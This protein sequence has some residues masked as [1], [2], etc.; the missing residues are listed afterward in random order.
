MSSLPQRE[1]VRLGVVTPGG[2]PSSAARAVALDGPAN[3]G[4]PVREQLEAFCAA[5]GTVTGM[6]VTARG[7]SHYREL[8]DAMLGGDVDLAWL[9]PVVAMRAAARGRMV[10]IALPVRNGTAYYSTALFT[11]SDSVLTS[12]EDLNGVRG[13]WVDRHSAAGYLVIR[14]ALRMRGVNLD[15]AFGRETFCGSHAGVV[16][17]V[18]EGMA[19]IGASFALIDP[20][21]KTPVR[22]GWGNAPVRV[23]A[24]AGPIPA[25]VIAATMRM[26]S[27]TLRV[28]QRALLMP[29]TEALKRA[30]NDLFAA[31]GFIEASAEHLA[32][33]NALLSHL[34]DRP[35]VGSIFPPAR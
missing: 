20:R 34:E 2:S 28:V 24:T 31:Q 30:A 18:L 25:D 21:R 16:R 11:R 7:I 10:P 29:P 5:L 27:A 8:L 26:P 12:L 13:A 19:D 14:G 15:R 17:A 23:L 33:L 3:A 4:G 22:A 1:Q 32:P 35:E 6:D 9:P